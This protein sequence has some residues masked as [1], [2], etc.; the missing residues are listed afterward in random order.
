M[1][2]LV[3]FI[4]SLYLN[5]S[6]NSVHC[7]VH[8]RRCRLSAAVSTGSATALTTAVGRKR[9][10]TKHA[11][12]SCL[13]NTN[14]KKPGARRA[15]PTLQT[16]LILSAV[17]PTMLDNYVPL[18]VVGDGNCLYR[19]FS[20]RCMA[21]KTYTSSC[22]WWLQWRSLVTSDPERADFFSDL[23]MYVGLPGYT[24]TLQAAIWHSTPPLSCSISTPWVRLSADRLCPP[25]RWRMITSNRQLL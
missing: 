22:V 4:I 23:A 16:T 15:R 24:E 20:L 19:A 25:V 12:F 13:K 18:T 6:N 2:T 21:Q 14:V 9:W 7:I 10:S 17:Q 11:T 5:V 1:V 3:T 8:G